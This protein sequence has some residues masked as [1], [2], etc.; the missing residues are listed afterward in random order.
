MIVKLRARFVAFS[1]LPTGHVSGIALIPDLEIHWC[2][3]RHGEEMGP[4]LKRRIERQMARLHTLFYVAD[5]FADNPRVYEKA[6]CFHPNV[7]SSDVMMSV[8]YVNKAF[9]HKL[10]D[11]Q[12]MEQTNGS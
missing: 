7:K 6:G 4:S 3:P 8:S 2:M 12:R 10:M 1:N 11:E 5:R 9:I